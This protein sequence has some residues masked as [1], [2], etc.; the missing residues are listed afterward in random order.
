MLT[1]LTES[2][3]R[4]LVFLGSQPPAPGDDGLR[5]GL[6]ADQVTPGFLG[7]LMT[8]FMVVSVVLLMLSMVRRIRRVRYRAHVDAAEEKGVGISDGSNSPMYDAGTQ[9]PDDG[10]TLVGAPSPR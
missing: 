1:S 2:A 7:F 8:A 10:G 6:S 5:P 3:T 9:L 4:G